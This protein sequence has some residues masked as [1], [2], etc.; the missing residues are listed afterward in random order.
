M[1]KPI[2]LL[3]PIAFV[4]SGC[5]GG[6][7]S[8]ISSSIGSYEVDDVSVYVYGQL[9]DFDAEGFGPTYITEHGYENPSQDYSGYKFE[10]EGESIRIDDGLIIGLKGNTDTA[11]TVTNP[12]GGVATFNVNVKNRTYSSQHEEAEESEGWFDDVEVNAINGIDDIHNGID[13]S[14]AYHIYTA[15][16]RY[17]GT[18]YDKDG[19]EQSLFYLLKDN[20]V[21]EIR[22]RLWVDP[23]NHNVVEED[24]SYATYG[25]GICDYEAVEWMAKEAT[26]AGLGYLLDLH[27]SDFWAHPGQ[28]VIP[29]AWA[30]ITTASDMAEQIYDYT[31]EVVSSLKEAGAT[32]TAVQI[33]NEI[34]TGM[35]LQSPGSDYSE[36]T[37]DNPGY[38]EEA[39]SAPSSIS[40]ALGSDNLV[41][42]LSQGIAAVKA[43]DEDI[44]TMIHIARGLTAS[45]DIISL[46]RS[47]SEVDYDI[48]GLSCYSYYQYSNNSTLV[49]H[50]NQ[51]ADAFPDKN[52]CAAET[53]YGFTYESDS[54]LGAIYN[55]SLKVSSYDT[56]IQGQADMLYDLTKAVA[57]LDNGYGVYYWEGA[58]KIQNPVGWADANSKNSWANQ[59]FF[60]YQG[61]ALGSLSVYDLMKGDQTIAN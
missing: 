40:G 54:Y 33:G 5:S 34:T 53:A 18:Y 12:D 29:K 46:Y 21:D 37:G 13:V 60:S 52:I 9:Y 43:V 59:G 51:I 3:L 2:V 7:S 48:I 41:N 36:L 26:S 30:D 20:G 14:S 49:Y 47:L 45:S 15:S 35:L 56:S 42:Y 55:E 28:Q 17:R 19:N 50:L 44:L 16:S 8:N 11:V 27:Y 6:T 39:K 38:V 10:Y 4:L 32:P 58:W 31:Y 22:L 57:D 1:K 23:Y 61:K 24:G 25:G